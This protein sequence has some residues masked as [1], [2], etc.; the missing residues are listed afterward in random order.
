M[1]GC[2][3]QDIG[4]W[5]SVMRWCEQDT[6]IIVCHKWEG[7]FANIERLCI[8]H[9][10]FCFG[11]LVLT[12]SCCPRKGKDISP[13]Y[14]MNVRER[15]DWSTTHFNYFTFGQGPLSEG[16]PGHVAGEGPL[17]LL[18]GLNSQIHSSVEWYCIDYGNPIPILSTSGFEADTISWCFVTTYLCAVCQQ[19]VILPY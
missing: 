2:C 10:W 8:S 9:E 5:R 4:T 1:M 18:P 6:A 3:E 13:F 19:H 15:C 12:P 14:P 7:I 16:L 17:M 11:D